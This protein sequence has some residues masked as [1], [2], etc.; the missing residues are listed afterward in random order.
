M[1][2]IKYLLDTNFVLGILKADSQVLA[3]LRAHNPAASECAYSAITR[4]E[5]LGFHNITKEEEK[6]INERLAHF[7]Y[8]PLTGEI[9]DQVIHLRQIRKIKLPDAIIAATA[10]CHKIK[11]LT[12]DQ[13]LLKT[14]EEVRAAE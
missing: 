10:H 2:G 8:L 6:L 12:R 9:E 11:L 14:A 7:A 1:N 3:E 5:L 4:M 13:S